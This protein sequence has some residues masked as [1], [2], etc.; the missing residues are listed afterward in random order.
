MSYKKFVTPSCFNGQIVSFSYFW[1]ENNFWR[2]TYDASESSEKRSRFQYLNWKD[3]SIQDQ[4]NLDDWIEN[5]NYLTE[6]PCIEENY[7]SDYYSEPSF[8]NDF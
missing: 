2:K 1:N 8:N 4:I 6:E 5:E 3:L 7:W